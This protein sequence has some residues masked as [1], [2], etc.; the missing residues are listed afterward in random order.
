MTGTAVCLGL[1]VPA[2]AAVA[3]P[4]VFV[5]LGRLPRRRPLAHLV[6]PL[7]S[8]VVLIPAHDEEATLP[9]ALHSIAAQDY[10]PDCVRVVVVADHCSDDTATVAAEHGATVVTRAAPDR[11]GKGY[12][13]AA[14][15]ESLGGGTFDAVLVLD[16]DCILNPTALREVARTLAAGAEVV[17]AAVWSRNADDGPAGFVAAVGAAVDAAVAAGRE[18]LG[19]HGRL[20]GTGMVFRT[21]VLDRVRWATVSPVEDAEYDRE[22]RNAGVR[23]RYCPGAEVTAAAPRRLAGL[24]R[25]RYRWAAA[26]PGGSKPLGLVLVALAAASCLAAGQFLVWAGALVAGTAAL[27]L[28]AVASLGI[29]LRRVGLFAATPAV[30][31][32][33]AVVAIVGWLKP[34][35]G[36][37]PSEARPA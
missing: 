9:A 27:Y 32:R 22:L 1:L 5:V 24:V 19:L 34:D 17:Q 11:R 30:V 14:G 12:A 16:A 35:R 15:L 20:R 33:L 31:A 3:V 8:V 2:T 25:Q 10:P 26:G 7:P 13:L 23:V 4:A 18:R 36:W 28:S 29:T 21:T 6:E 37:F